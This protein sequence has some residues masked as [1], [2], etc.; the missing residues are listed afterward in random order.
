MTLIQ[1]RNHEARGIIESAKRVECKTFGDVAVYR[2][3]TD[4]AIAI[5]R[6][7]LPDGRELIDQIEQLGRLKCKLELLSEQPKEK[8]PKC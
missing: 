6:T 7:G 4:E 2:E 3:T 1:V 8:T 5:L